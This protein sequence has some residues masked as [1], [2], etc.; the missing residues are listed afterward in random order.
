MVEDNICK[1]WL[2]ISNKNK[3]CNRKACHNSDFCQY[4]KKS[5]IYM[6]QSANIQKNISDKHNINDKTED[7]KIIDYKY[8]DLLCPETLLGLYE[9]WVEVPQIF[10]VQLNNKW[11]DIRILTD[12]FSNQLNLTELENPKPSY[13]HD[14]FTR[15]NFSAKELDIYKNMCYSLKLKIYIGLKIFLD[16][17]IYQSYEQ[18]YGTS[19]IMC[20][21]II[22]LFSEK[23]RFRIVNNKNSQDSY[24][25]IWV[26]KNYP[27]SCFE[28]L[29]KLY[30]SIPFQLGINTDHG[31]LL[32]DNETKMLVK[33]YLDDV[34]KECINL[35]SPDLCV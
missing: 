15:K 19:K 33:N 3:R 29:Y 23:M 4:H 35:N 34:D 28:I 10:W 7:N 21:R 17:N 2:N 25:G 24:T 22:N 9:S 6:P 13:P 16:S 26:D 14:P 31:L 30:I 27:K 11:W 32:F 20:Q 8:L 12:I 5:A 1:S 18:N